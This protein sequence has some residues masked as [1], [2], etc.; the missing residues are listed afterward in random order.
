MSLLDVILQ[1]ELPRDAWFETR[2]LQQ[3][4]IRRS[5]LPTTQ[6]EG[7]RYTSL[8][9]LAARN[10]VLHDAGSAAYKLPEELLQRMQTAPL[11]LVFVNGDLQADL[12][13]LT[14][15]PSGLSIMPWMTSN[16]GLSTE[17]Y[18][19][20]EKPLPI[21]AAANLVLAHSGVHINVDGNAKIS[22]ALRIFLI[23]APAE[24]ELA[25]HVRFVVSL[26]AGA[27][28]NLIEEHVEIAPVAHLSNHF[29]EVSAGH[30]ARLTH[31]RTDT[32]SNSRSTID[33]NRYRLAE[34]AT[35]TYFELTSGL[36]LYRHEIQVELT[37][38]TASFVSGGVL[39]LCGRRHADVQISVRHLAINT[40][41]NLVWRGLASERARAAFGGNLIVEAGAD[42]ADA[43]LSNKNLLLSSHAEINT[44]PVLEIH[45]DEVQAAHGATVGSL[46]EQALFYLRSRGIDLLAAHSLLTRAFAMESLLLLEDA[47]IRSLMEAAMIEAISAFDLSD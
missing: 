5:G 6:T 10:F 47:R 20:D 45:A 24:N 7:W 30:G 34:N 12:S 35:V 22:A 40:R 27:E 8:R 37:G 32:A 25:T 26:A 17:T 16:T 13:T 39:A 11:R 43:K 31:T 15:L 1:A 46:D 44:K 36:A 9:A 33:F 23:A 29:L 3:E 14:A 19:P 38:K 18:V 21:F 41:S 4:R 28:L 2:Q 42:G